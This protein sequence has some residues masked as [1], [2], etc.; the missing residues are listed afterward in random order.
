[1]SL[2][3]IAIVM[4][5]GALGGMF[6]ALLG[7]G[8]GIFIVPFLTLGFGLPFRQAAGIGLMTVIAT[9]SVVSA[10]AVLP[11]TP[12]VSA[13]AAISSEPPMSASLMAGPAP[14]KGS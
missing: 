2:L 13:Y 8:G 5:L 12:A 11:S 6:G 14:R 7:L 10:P 3:A 4:A 1:M 9:S